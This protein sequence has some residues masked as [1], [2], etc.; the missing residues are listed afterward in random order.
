[1]QVQMRIPLHELTQERKNSLIYTAQVKEPSKPFDVYAYAVHPTSASVPW[2]VA[3]HQWRIP[4]PTPDPVSAAIAIST[5]TTI[6][7]V[8]EPFL[9][10]LVETCRSNAKGGVLCLSTGF[11]KTA[12]ALHAVAKLGVKTLIITHKSFLMDQWSTRI[13][14]HLAMGDTK[15]ARWVQDKCPNASDAS[16]GIVLGSIQTLIQDRI[17][18]RDIAAQKFGL[19]I[20][21]ECHHVSAKGFSRCLLKTDCIPMT[22]GL[23]AT[24][25]RPDGLMPMAFLFLGNIIAESKSTIGTPRVFLRRSPCAVKMAYQRFSKKDLDHSTSITLLSQN[26]ERN[27]FI[28]DMIKSIWKTEP[29]RAIL[30]LSERR[31]HCDDLKAATPNSHVFY[32][33][34][35]LPDIKS[36]H[37]VFATYQ[38]CAEGFDV[39]ILDTL[40]LATP[41]SGLERLEQ[42]VGRILRKPHPYAPE[43]YDISDRHAVYVAMGGKRHAYY[44]SKHYTVSDVVSTQV[45]SITFDTCML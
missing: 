18:E 16:I 37:A 44:K 6:R 10:T 20:Y 29:R 1:M 5:R 38:M 12:I 34:T 14:D 13:V 40:V 7:P 25:S 22:V 23:S 24:P 42:C 41:I 4:Q 36:G 11:G 39:P 27:Q 17:L 45:P 2:R 31:Q 8:Q 43:V 28:V 35:P 19:V 33:G 32:A 3:V 26:A 30:V 9:N 15:V 21:D